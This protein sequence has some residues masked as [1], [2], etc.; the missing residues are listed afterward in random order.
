[1]GK[2]RS[3][4]GFLASLAMIFFTANALAEGYTC[5]EYKK[6]TSCNSGYYLNSASVGNACVAC[7]TA[8]NTTSTQACST[9]ASITNGTRVSSGTQTCAGYYTGSKDGADS[10]VGAANACEGCS[11]WGACTY[12]SYVCNCNSGYH[13]EGTGAACTCVSDT[14]TC[15]A[16]QYL[17]ANSKTCS[18]CKAGYKCPSSAATY[19]PGTSD[20]GLTACSGTLE[21]QNL[22]GQTACKTVDAGYYKTDNTTQTQCPENYRDGSGA[23]NQNAC[24]G[25]FTKTGAINE[26]TNP[27][28]TYCATVTCG[29]CTPGTCTYKKN[30][31]G[32]ITSDCTATSCTKP[33]SAVT[34]KANAYVSNLT[35]TACPSGYPNSAGGNIAITQCYSNTKTREWTGKETEC[36]LPTGCATVVCNSCTGTACEYTAYSNSTGTADGTVKSGCSTNNTACPQ[37]VKSVTAAEN[38][39]ASTTATS[40]TACSTT[41]PTYPYS[42]AGATASSSCYRACTTADVAN[43][44]G[45]VN[46][47]VY[48]SG[49][50][51]CT[52]TGC[53]STHYLY[54]NVCNL[55]P[56]GGI[57]CP[58]G[59]TGLCCDTGYT[60]TS[61][62]TCTPNTYTVTYSCGDGS[63][64]APASGYPEYNGSFTPANN[65]CT[66]AN[67]QFNGWLV[68]GTSDIKKPGA[69]FTWQY[70]ANKTFTAQWI[71]T[72][73]NCQEGEYYDG[74][75]CQSCPSGYTS[76]LGADAD[77]KCYKASTM[78]C[79]VPAA[80][81][82]NSTYCS[83][84]TTTTVECN[85]YYNGT[86][87]PTG[88]QYC[89][90]KKLSCSG[91]YYGT[92]TS[93]E[94]CSSLG[95]G[96]WATSAGGTGA[97]S[98]YAMCTYDCNTELASL[99]P[100]HAT[101]SLVDRY[102]D[103]GEF[104]PQKQ[105]E[106]TTTS[107]SVTSCT[108]E[109]GYTFRMPTGTAGDIGSCD[110]NTYTITLNDNGGTG[111]A[112]TVYQ[113]FATGWSLT[114][115]GT[116]ITKV[117]VPTR[118][119][120]N[121]TFLG[122]FES[123]SGGT[124]I[125]SADG[126]LPSNT[127]F[128]ADTTLY[129]QWSQNNF[130]CTAGQTYDGKTCPAGSFCPG[131]S[132]P[133]G[134]QSDTTTGCQRTC[135]ADTGGGVV[136][137]AAGSITNT[138]CTATRSNYSSTDMHGSADQ[139]CNYSGTAYNATCSINITKCDAGYYDAGTTVNG[140][141]DCIP[142][143]NNFYSPEQAFFSD[144]PAKPNQ[145]EQAGSSTKRY[146]C[147]D[148][149][150]TSTTTAS[151]NTACYQTCADITITNGKGIAAVAS[152]QYDGT[153][154][155]ACTYTAQ[156]N[157]GYSA[158]N[159]TTATTTPA[160]EQCGDGYYCPS[161]DGESGGEK[162]KCPDGY[163]HSAENP[164][165]INDCY[166]ECDLAANATQMSGIE[167]YQGTNSCAIVRCESNYQLSGGKC[168]ICPEGKVCDGTDKEP[169]DCPED[170]Y[171]PSG[172]DE[173]VACP[174]E[175][176][177][178]S[179]GTTKEADCYRACT[180]QDIT[181]ATTVSGTLTKGGTNTCVATSC[182]AGTYL[183]NGKC[184]K[185]PAGMTCTGGTTEPKPCEEGYYCPEGGDTPQACPASHPLSTATA[186]SESDCYTTCEEYKIEGGTATPV[187]AK[188]FYPGKCEYKGV[189]DTGNPCDIVNNV[190]I[191]SSCNSN[192]E[193]INGRCQLCSRENALSY[194]PEGNCVIAS[195][196]IGYHPNGLVCEEDI[197]ECDMPNATYAEQTWDTKLGAF[198]IC[199]IK[200]CEDGYHLAS[201]ACVLDE[202]A[203]VVENG[204]GIKE[205]NH[206]TNTWGQCVATSC[207]PGYTDDPSET[208]ERTKPCGQ[209]K[210]KFSV[211]GELAASSYVRGCE[212]ASC[213]YQGELYNLE[214]NECVP[215][216]D[217]NGYE[218]ETG[219]EK[220]DASRKKCVRT[221]KEGYTM[222]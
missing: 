144:E 147:P 85:Q 14:V 61:D 182:E 81:P 97:E 6:Y 212:I 154:Y 107:C 179:V 104:Y 127:T 134:T 28:T 25:N 62:T 72:A 79:V 36:D 111:G 121:Y 17:P 195:C 37:T 106:L 138:S 77:T 112:G 116:T 176:P 94:K 87:E 58:D 1:M 213:M 65:T 146:E 20:Q 186:A 152:V 4:L 35:C 8:S 76:D 43:S 42:D 190:C 103:G 54:N 191:E 175:Y 149:G 24:V 3:F 11:A 113:K 125:I 29:T 155:A 105:C 139:T 56:T 84:Q 170:H 142:V 130:T 203:C 200:E 171:C 159:G 141:R 46:G 18:T 98:C 34:A 120:S 78:A 50:S 205:W 183:G 55:L 198:G 173:P 194:K 148:G 100:E 59:S 90:I 73:G 181:G 129:A 145:G 86:C 45:T 51:N 124:A 177:N 44:S 40:C 9:S 5:P 143:G 178:S 162:Q 215:I 33:V 136:T 219:Y 102:L 188:A 161:G 193:L 128:T 208:N 168:V 15:A 197:R 164:K 117:S 169:E 207:D 211:L 115:F 71:Q 108:C 166:K 217:V 92:S 75:T 204:T 126:T 123:Q 151:R 89:P 39:W 83:Y 133:A 122:Y 187:E 48:A 218:D 69:S 70:T 27:S 93:C 32:T 192:Y 10:T 52:A 174:T 140:E 47:K 22:T 202:Q 101:C 80:C 16:G 209:C 63:G 157:E 165:T 38:Y 30:Y 214:N 199:T 19:T 135:P 222:W 26:C 64:T 12:S 220:W 221:C 67:W 91:G 150:L 96:Y 66:R 99:T 184:V 216:C 95:D 21:Y 82:D 119:G 114:N 41:N 180:V 189:S 167:Y 13:S 156:C 57:T 172:T 31:A 201:N 118:D 210:N 68:S 185:C 137:S 23:A 109:D 60:K 2:K 160:C 7:S 206:S 158:V 132:V 110:P 74:T 53:K 88:D 153:K 196:V 163:P 131:G 49:V